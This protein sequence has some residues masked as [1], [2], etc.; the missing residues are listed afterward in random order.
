MTTSL[1]SF[2]SQ[3]PAYDNIPDDQLLDALYKKFGGQ[4]DSFDFKLDMLGKKRAT[5]T[6]AGVAGFET[7]MKT[8]GAT[9][10]NRLGYK[11]TAENIEKS[12]EEQQAD[13]ASRYR[14]QVP[15]VSDIK[16]LGTFGTYA[17]ERALESLAYAAP[18]IVGGL[19]GSLAG[20]VGAVAGAAAGQYPVSVAQNLQEQMKEGKGIEDTSL[21]AAALTAVPQAAVQGATEA[22]LSPIAGSAG[23]II[24]NIATSLGRKGAASWIERGVTK[25]LEGGAVDSLS[26][27]G[28]QALTIL[29]ANPEKLY[30][31]GP[32]VQK[33]L[34]EA[35]VPGALMGASMGTVRGILRGKGAEEVPAKGEVPVAETPAEEAPPEKPVAINEGPLV[36]GNETP[37][38]I[39]PDFPE[40]QWIKDNGN[41]IAALD[42]ETLPMELSPESGTPLGA[43]PKDNRRYFFSNDVVDSTT[44]S[45]LLFANQRELTA[46][47]TGTKPLDIQHID[48]PDTS[49]VVKE[50][51][52]SADMPKKADV[53]P[54]DTFN[55]IVQDAK[56]V[57]YRPSTV[58]D[59]SFENLP[60]KALYA[61]TRADAE[62]LNPNYQTY[63]DYLTQGLGIKEEDIPTLAKKVEDSVSTTLVKAQDD[64]ANG[65]IKPEDPVIVP[66][67]SDIASKITFPD[68]PPKTIGGIDPESKDPADQKIV[69]DILNNTKSTL[70]PKLDALFPGMNDMLRD[71]HLKLFPGT[72]IEFKT[73][74]LNSGT[75]GQSTRYNMLGKEKT[76]T[77]AIDPK[78]IKDKEDIL[79]TM[80]HE[81]A[82]VIEYTW[83]NNLDSPT[84]KSVID[85]YVKE[86]RP[87]V[88]NRMALERVIPKVA[89]GQ[90]GLSQSE[91]SNILS[92]SFKKTPEGMVPK[93]SALKELEARPD[94][95]FK[96]A[97]WVAE[98]GASWMADRNRLPTS[99]F[100]AFRKNIVD[101][102]KY[103]YRSIASFLGIQPNQGAFERLM[104]SVYGKARETPGY[105][106]HVTRRVRRESADAAMAAGIPISG[107]DPSVSRKPTA[108]V[109][110][111]YRPGY[112]SSG[113]R[114][115]TEEHPLTEQD[116]R[117]HGANPVLLDKQT[118]SS[119]QTQGLFMTSKEPKGYWAGVFDRFT[120]REQGETYLQA[121]VRNN[122]ASQMP[123]LKRADLR[124]VGRTLER[125]QNAQGRMSALIH[126]GYLSY[127]R[128]TGSLSLNNELGGLAKIMEKAGLTGEKDL[129]LFMIARREQDLRKRGRSGFG[130]KYPGTDKPLTDKDL[131]DIVNKTPAHIKEVGD[132]IF[133]FNQKMVQFSVDTGVIPKEL[134]DNLMSL[135]YTPFYRAQDA[136][137]ANNGNLTVAPEIGNLLKNPTAITLFNQKLTAGG[138][139]E[140]NF[141]ENT[142]RN[143]S[144]IVTAGLKNIAY[145]KAAEALTNLNDKTIA[146]AVGI[147]G[148]N[149]I[150]YRLNGSDK[151]MQINDIPMFHALAAFSPKQLDG[152][153][154]AAAQ[155]AQFMRKGVVTAPP[156]MIANYIK[157]FIDVKIKTGMPLMELMRGSISGMK[158]ALSH[159]TSSQAIQAATGFGGFRYGSSSKSQADAL[160]SQY[161]LKEG[162]ATLWQRAMHG[163][164]KLENLGDASEMGPRIA[165]Y[166]HLIKQGYNHDTAAWEAVNLQNFSRSGTGKGVF[167]SVLANLIPM[168]P[169]LNARIQGLYRLVE[170]GTAGGGKDLFKRSD[171]LAI[172][173]AVAMRGLALVG[174][175]A[176]LN[177]WNG[178]E[179]WYKKLTINDRINNNYIPLGGTTVLA[180]PRAFEY[181]SIFGALPGVMLDA[182]RQQDGSIAAEGASQILQSTFLFN[183]I[184]QVVAP[185]AQVYYNKQ[186]FTGRTIETQADQNMPKSERFDENTSE[187]AKFLGKVGSYLPLIKNVSPKQYDVLMSGYTGTL[188]T[189]FLAVSDGI[190][191]AAGTRPQ[192]AFGD[193]TSVAGIAANISGASRFVKNTDTM[194]N[195]Y[196][197]DFY[198]MKQNVT[199]LVTSM[200]TAQDSANFDDLRS[201]MEANPT[202]KA[203]YTVLNRVEN[204]IA[205]LN[206]EAKKLRENTA[207][208]SDQKIERLQQIRTAKNKLAEQAVTIGKQFG[209]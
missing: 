171:V 60:D 125:M 44:N 39:P 130:Y 92:N 86:A 135:M 58:K 193:P 208:D 190:F 192:G 19:V 48:I 161:A 20:P 69:Q 93:G 121:I 80:F 131:A 1:E 5:S 49:P 127:D 52:P 90:S 9:V 83:I 153:V 84:L 76:F 132:N 209:F 124:E 186:F 201:K 163:L 126:S 101:K 29:Q 73:E 141:Y 168:V 45:P 28:Q 113:D 99:S 199:E 13:I 158:D 91:I 150:T 21:K 166:N 41:R 110:E 189:T 157:G 4:G 2:R 100:D 143:Y 111:E 151:H 43:V 159:G 112:T 97:E 40:S 79:H 31:F 56:P 175:E 109:T 119:I 36:P 167:G 81:L 82:H 32:D 10:L 102:L 149:T 23:S 181:G 66:R 35:A 140:A 70:D 156:F 204:Q 38:P 120:G 182:I 162:T 118:P 7:G 55:T 136:E 160:R 33:E 138:Q 170:P 87:T 133:K 174:I 14:P 67:T 145:G 96:F 194:A 98:K 188:G 11:E 116:I 165:Y 26:M 137:I 108:V 179:D 51:T 72:N 139:I 198:T 129:Q 148:K 202:A 6:E 65:K 89:R 77:I 196:L 203:A 46:M 17:K 16:D 59:I 185:L 123:F 146:Q 71:L 144:S 94:Y 184:P 3:Y 117:E 155:V 61:V 177:L 63:K 95:L 37:V 103:M 27:A 64:I 34:I 200:K 178:D 42:K 57:D 74:K 62:K 197:S 15:S 115:V 191:A 107:V 152:F 8:L 24:G 25:A 47:E 154:G 54:Q 205:K 30:E 106:D 195:K 207:I 78:Q 122:V 134:G 147:P 172:P 105:S 88:N 12:A 206:N 187:V 176:G 164:E 22:F 128:A 183:P 18:S 50:I 68:E 173:A 85:Q 104:E 114:V 180:I 169:F 75:L 53:L 142:F